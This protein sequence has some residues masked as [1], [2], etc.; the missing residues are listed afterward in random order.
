MEEIAHQA[1]TKVNAVVNTAV[2]NHLSLWLLRLALSSTQYCS[3]SA[4][5]RSQ[6]PPDTGL[7][8]NHMKWA[9]SEKAEVPGGQGDVQGHLVVG[10]RARVNRVVCSEPVLCATGSLLSQ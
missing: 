9:L 10:G 6:C 7:P 5:H 4:K 3:Q 2:G 8:S 1:V